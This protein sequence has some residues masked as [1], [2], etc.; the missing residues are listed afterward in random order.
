MK[1]PFDE[2][3]QYMLIKYI[4]DENATEFLPY[5]DDSL[6][7]TQEL[8]E[9]IKF[10]KDW[11]TK[12]FNVPGWKAIDQKCG[13]IYIDDNDVLTPLKQKIIDAMEKIEATKVNVNEVRS[14]LV[15]FVKAQQSRK[16]LVQMTVDFE[17]GKYSVVDYRRKLDEILHVENIDKYGIFFSKYEIEKHQRAERFATHLP[18]L[19]EWMGGGLARGELG[20]FFAQTNLGKS[21]FLVNISAKTY[22]CDKN[23]FYYSFELD[24]HEIYIR[25][26]QRITGYKADYIYNNLGRYRRKLHKE[27]DVKKG[28]IVIQRYPTKGA[29]VAEIASHMKYVEATFGI[30]PDVVCVDYADYVRPDHWYNDDHERVASVIESL[31]GLAVQENVAVWTVSQIKQEEYDSELYMNSGARSIRKMEASDFA[32]G[33]YL[34]LDNKKEAHVKWLKARRSKRPNKDKF[35]ILKDYDIALQKEIMN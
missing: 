13:G 11:T 21:F 4:I 33:M 6:F 16:L 27:I 5:L 34:D 31:R 9:M 32:A 23:V 1:Y 19:T 26:G 12:E 24:E 18:T 22:I 20:L 14:V 7:D 25:I 30:R 35:K 10:I 8:K 2:E 28:E 17:R 3:F 15:D 29:T